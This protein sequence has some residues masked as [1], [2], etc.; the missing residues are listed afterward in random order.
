MTK[1]TAVIIGCGA[2]AREHLSAIAGLEDV[3]VAAVCDLSAARAEAAAE[4]FGVAQWFTDN[5]QM[6]GQTK[7]DLV[8]I[9]TPPDSHFSI[10]QTCLSR[11]LNVLCEKPIT[12]DYRQFELLK[13]LALENDCILLENQNLRFHSSI[14]RIQDL[15]SVG[16]FGDLI[17]VQ[18]FFALNLVGASSPYVDTNVPHF[19][20][21]L[22]GGIIGDFL[23]H[24]AYLAL[25]FTGATKDVRTFWAKRTT[26]TLLPSDEFRAIIKGERAPAYVGFSANSQ[27]NGY[28][29]RVTGTR[30]SVE[31]NLL[32]PPRL[33]FRR[34]RGGEPAI[35]S[36]IGGIAEARELFSGTIAAFWRKLAGTSS[37][38]GL[39]EMISATHRALAT[40]Q[41][42]PISLQE[43]DMAAQ[44][45]SQ[46]TEQA[47]QL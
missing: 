41:P 35:A 8:H 17:D 19:A 21:A 39:A 18:I 24:I 4:K 26:D 6:L 12:V 36:L 15:L 11:R 30:M 22:K 25:L 28:W 23:P 27:V 7:P 20:L 45:V 40:N 2:I 33:T 16:Q 3:T 9:A 44:L 13:Q 42:P 14:R 1:S 47:L 5:E 32:E 34:Y 29:V 43:I 10:A 37:Y 46:F 38:D 31:A